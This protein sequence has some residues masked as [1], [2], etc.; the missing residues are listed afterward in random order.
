MKFA[1]K[2]TLMPAVAGLAFAALFLSNE[3][4][5]T[6]DARLMS[7]IRMEY[8]PAVEVS[9]DM[10]A[11]LAELQRALQDAALEAWHGKKENLKAGQQA[12][13]HRAKCNSA[14]AVGRYTDGM[15]REPL[16]SSAA[17]RSTRKKAT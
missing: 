8:T 12:F 14:A 5:R 11:G 7:Q 15:E 2:V 13:H 17:V 10:E 16:G 6:R 9:R 3:V 4:L 1:H